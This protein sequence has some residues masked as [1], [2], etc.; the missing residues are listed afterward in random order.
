MMIHVK[1]GD[2]ILEPGDW[3]AIV[4]WSGTQLNYVAEWER[5]IFR[6][7][8]ARWFLQRD[9]ADDALEI[10]LV[11]G[12]GKYG[13][14]TIH[15]PRLALEFKMRWCTPRPISIGTSFAERRW[16]CC[17]EQHLYVRRG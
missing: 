12:S 16:S 9:V 3:N 1:N 4:M 15:D 7:A 8:I 10:F 11:A 17:A 5:I 13:C 6:P 2:F 14:I